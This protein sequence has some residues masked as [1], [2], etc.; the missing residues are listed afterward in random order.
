MRKGIKCIK[1]IFVSYC[2][3][4]G[5]LQTLYIL[6]GFMPGYGLPG[7]LGYVSERAFGAGI[8]FSIIHF[9]ITSDYFDDKISIKIRIFV[10]AIPCSVVMGYLSYELGLHNYLQF[11]N[12]DLTYVTLWRIFMLVSFIIYMAIYWVIEWNYLKQGKEY[13]IALQAYKDKNKME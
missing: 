3:A 7:A 2:F 8:V 10:C 11:I 5:L 13:D 9:I 12:D 4:F 6:Q 1:E